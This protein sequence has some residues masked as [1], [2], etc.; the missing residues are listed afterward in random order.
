M[1]VPAA[2]GSAQPV[3]TGGLVNV[4]IVDV[5]SGNQVSLTVP[6]AVA[7]NICDVSVNVLAVDLSQDGRATCNSATRQIVDGGPPPNPVPPSR[8][9][10]TEGLQPGGPLDVADQLITSLSATIG[11]SCFDA[12]RGVVAAD[13]GLQLMSPPVEDSEDAVAAGS[14]DLPDVIVLRGAVPTRASKRFGSR[15]EVRAGPAPRIATD[16]E[17]RT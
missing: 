9:S 7:A 15:A 11:G 10:R 4:T 1:L 2:T 12:L 6:I 5:L 3:F 16:Q 13:P 14:G 8:S 17:R